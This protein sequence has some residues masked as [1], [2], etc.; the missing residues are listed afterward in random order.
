[1]YAL[2]QHNVISSVSNL[3]TANFYANSMADNSLP[4]GQYLTDI[5]AGNEIRANGVGL[6][7]TS[8]LISGW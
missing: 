1:M 3:N 8:L 7:T 2:A 6:S 5:G 4:P